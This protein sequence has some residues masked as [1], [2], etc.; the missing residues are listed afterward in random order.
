MSAKPHRSRLHEKDFAPDWQARCE[1][2]GASPTVTV[3]GL[4]GP[5]HFGT[6]SASGGGWWD[7]GKNAFDEDFVEEH[8]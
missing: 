2:C 5:C 8:L 6:A 7:D 4:C 1:N 3:S